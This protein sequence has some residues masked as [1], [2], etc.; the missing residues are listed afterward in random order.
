MKQS[1]S[2]EPAAQQEEKESKHRRRYQRMTTM[3]YV[4]LVHPLSLAV[5]IAP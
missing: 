3:N 1:W 4:T 5:L 2:V